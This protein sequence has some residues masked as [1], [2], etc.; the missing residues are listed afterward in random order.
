MTNVVALKLARFIGRLT[1]AKR[2]L[3]RVVYR[4]RICAAHR[5]I[6]RFVHNFF[7]AVFVYRGNKL[8]SGKGIDGH[9]NQRVIRTIRKVNAQHNSQNYPNITAARS[10]GRRKPV[11]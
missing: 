9:R 7:H 4:R 6:L 10:L 8:V 11:H 3:R 2:H 1:V 5:A